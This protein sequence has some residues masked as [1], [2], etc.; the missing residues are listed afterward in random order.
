M[1][2]DNHNAYCLTSMQRIKPN[3]IAIKASSAAIW[4][5][6][7]YYLPNDKILYWFKLKAFADDKMNL[8]E[9][10]KLVFEKVENIVITSIFSFSNNVFKS[11][12]F[13]GR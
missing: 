12:L 1:L 7:L 8:N 3:R 9:I 2:V 5:Q 13:Q 10:F 11:L 4:F 6:V